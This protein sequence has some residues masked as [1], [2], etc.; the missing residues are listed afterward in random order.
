MSLA[1]PPAHAADKGTARAWLH[2]CS[3]GNA[4]L[5]ISMLR[6]VLWVLALLYTWPAAALLTPLHLSTVTP[7]AGKRLEGR[8]KEGE[9]RDRP[10]HLTLQQL[11]GGIRKSV[12]DAL[13]PTPQVG[14]DST[15]GNRFNPLRCMSRMRYRP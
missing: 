8:L 4:G 12:S 1:T 3:V 2:A 11:R 15:F 6:R 5:S 10:L 7:A 9:P 13:R 14:L